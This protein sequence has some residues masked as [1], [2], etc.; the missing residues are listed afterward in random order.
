MKTVFTH[1][2]CN[3]NSKQILEQRQIDSNAHILPGSEGNF[4]SPFYKPRE[5]IPPPGYKSIFNSPRP[6]KGCGA[7]KQ[8]RRQRL[9]TE[10]GNLSPLPHAQWHPTQ[11][12]GG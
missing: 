3:C 11:N 6:R 10:R 12:E 4:L 2:Q 8:R 5:F 9:A 7:A 1:F